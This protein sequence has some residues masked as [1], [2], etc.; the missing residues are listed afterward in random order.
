MDR[1]GREEGMVIKEPHA[2]TMQC[3]KCSVLTA[4]VT[5]S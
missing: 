4:S 1:A 2:E 3:W 5:L